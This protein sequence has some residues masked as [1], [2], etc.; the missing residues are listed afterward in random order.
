MKSKK[1]SGAHRKLHETLPQIEERL[2][3]R[4]KAVMWDVFQTGI[5]EERMR[6]IVCDRFRWACAF[7]GGWRRAAVHVKQ[8]THAG[9]C[10]AVPAPRCRDPSAQQQSEH[11]SE[12]LTEMTSIA[13]IVDVPAMP[14]PLSL[15]N[16][17]AFKQCVS[18]RAQDLRQNRPH[19][20]DA[21]L[22]KYD[23]LVDQLVFDQASADALGRGAQDL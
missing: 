14:G 12:N 11:I 21:A 8:D 23:E 17:N 6:Q 18:R 13:S 4:A 22:A 20:T 5:S 16:G 19:T 1:R 9:S 15:C 10:P 3:T 2:Q 7:L